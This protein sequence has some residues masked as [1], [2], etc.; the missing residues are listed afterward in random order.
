[1]T[2]DGPQYTKTVTL[3]GPPNS[4][5]AWK[6]IYLNVQ[7]QFIRWTISDNGQTGFKILGHTALGSSSRETNTIN[8]FNN[9]NDYRLSNLPTSII[10]PENQDDVPW[11]LNR[12][13][14]D[15]AFA[16]NQKD[17][18]IFQM[19]ISA[20]PTQIPNL[21]TT[22]AYMVTVSGSAPFY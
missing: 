8:G 17:N 6:R 12:L 3:D 16:I 18:G 20:A 22:G 9:N 4:D 21:D 2:N 11:F 15:M 1:M 5:F 14:E 10:W 7:A 19:A 13:Y